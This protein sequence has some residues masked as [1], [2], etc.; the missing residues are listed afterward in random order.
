MWPES[1]LHNTDLV[2][3]P[4]RSSSSGA[5]NTRELSFSTHKS[6]YLANDVNGN[7]KSYSIGCTL[8]SVTFEGRF[9]D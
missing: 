9:S 1:F 4:V 2:D 5:L 8:P 6:L 7:K 3:I